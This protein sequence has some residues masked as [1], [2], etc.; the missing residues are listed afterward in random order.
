MIYN[1]KTI[2]FEISSAGAYSHKVI[3]FTPDGTFIGDVYL[4]SKSFENR[5]QMLEEIYTHTAI[6]KLEGYGIYVCLSEY[7]GIYERLSQY[8][9]E[10]IVRGMLH[11]FETNFLK[12]NGSSLLEKFKES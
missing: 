2:S 3:C 9:Y 5:S 12:T 8:D 4:V 6:S 1:K 11:C 7:C 10:E